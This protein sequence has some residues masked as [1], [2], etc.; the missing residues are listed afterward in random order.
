MDFQTIYEGNVRNGNG[1]YPTWG[2]DVNPS[3]VY[4]LDVTANS[5][6]TLEKR[7]YIEGK[8]WVVEYD[9]DQKT[10]S[11]GTKTK[12]T[13]TWLRDEH[14]NSAFY[15][16]KNIRF[17]RSGTDMAGTSIDIDA[18]YFYTFS[19]ISDNV[20][21]DSSLLNTT[22]HNNIG[23]DAKDNVF[24]GDTYN[25]IILPECQGNLFVGGCHDSVI[26][27]ASV[28]NIFVEPVCYLTGSI[29]GKTLYKG[30]T[31]LST[32]IS[33]TVHKVNDKTIVSYLDPETYAYQVV[34]L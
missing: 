22:T 13:I 33:K 23:A 12:G 21:T 10:L 19:D 2:L 5:E 26:G 11:D 16:F 27:F 34:Q 4:V 31:T 18:G 8:D 9:S 20:I 24:I 15:D 28:N 17:Y 14:D 30:D 3:Q 1:T 29:Y 6:T 25:N 32:S 7:A